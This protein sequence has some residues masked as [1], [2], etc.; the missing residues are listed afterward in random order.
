MKYNQFL[1]LKESVYDIG[2]FFKK[3]LIAILNIFKNIILGSLIM[4]RDIFIAILNKLIG[5]STLAFIIGIGL[6]IYN[7]YQFFKI[8]ISIIDTKYF[9]ISIILC[10]VHIVLSFIY[11]ILSNDT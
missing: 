2:R 11:A 9:F 7:F 6:M 3:I 10:G 8:D 4:L 1:F 5:I